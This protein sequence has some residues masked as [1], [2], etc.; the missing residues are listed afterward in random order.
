MS[1]RL[2]CRWL[3]SCSSRAALAGSAAALALGCTHLSRSR[4]L[5]GRLAGPVILSPLPLPVPL[6]PTLQH[7]PQVANQQG[8]YLADLF[9]MHRVGGVVDP[10][11]ANGLPT[12]SPQFHYRHLGA[13]ATH[14][15]LHNAQ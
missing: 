13:P 6:P 3:C 15:L 11:S 9:N 4:R 1:L 14:I 8:R 2:L 7:Y 12:T 5:H 10:A